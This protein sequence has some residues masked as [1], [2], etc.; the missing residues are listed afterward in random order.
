MFTP[1][2][3]SASSALALSPLR[4]SAQVLFGSRS[5]DGAES[6][7]VVYDAEQQTLVARRVGSPSAVSP[8]QASNRCPLCNSELGNNV[9]SE[10]DYFSTLSY[11]HKTQPLLSGTATPDNP[12]LPRSPTEAARDLHDLSAN[13]L[14]NGYYHRFFEEIRLLG[15]GSFGSVFL[16]RHVIDGVHL[17]EFAVKKVPV[18]DSREWLRGMMREV[19]ALERLATHP[20]IVAYKHS[21]LEM[22]RANEFCP[23]VPYLFILMSFCDGG[24][25]ESL[26]TTSS[27]SDELVWSLFLYI[28]QGLQ[29][30]HRNFVVHRDLKL[31]NILLTGS[32]NI[33]AVLSDFGTAEI[34][35]GN[36]RPTA[37]ATT[38]FTGTAEY[39]APE[40]FQ[41]RT[42]SE[43]AD[44][45]SLGIVLFAMCFGKVPYANPDPT[46]CA[47]MI[48]ESSSVEIPK[49]SSR[50][51]DLH[52]MITALTSKDPT[53]RPSC[54]DILFQPF[55]RQKLEQQRRL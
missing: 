32:P 44:M 23:F 46:V 29:H 18:G 27:L 55:V 51:P 53:R 17:G 3:P 50:D 39:T 30:L 12:F 26:V 40:V 52:A 42:Y 33:R 31:S 2:R 36:G 16:C 11:F 4:G 45:W 15:T 37:S 14:V 20:N 9:A 8:Q 10:P 34:V 1:H 47:R 5:P 6:A 25:L 43:A 19:K 13:L 41:A 38:G 28:C 35:S 24:S 7:V 21:W 54:D 49:S 22:H 48:I